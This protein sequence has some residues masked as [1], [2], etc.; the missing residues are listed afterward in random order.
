MDD[1]LQQKYLSIPEE[2]NDRFEQ[3][4]ARFN[5]ILKEF[6]PITL[7]EM[8]DV[9]LMN[10]VDTKFLLNINDLPY[11]LEKAKKQYRVVSIKGEKISP[12][13][14][15]YFDTE[16]SN[17]YISHHNGKRNRYKVRTRTYINP[18]I[19]FL[20]IKHKNN[21]GRVS[22]S[23]IKIPLEQFLH[24]RFNQDEAGFIEK[25]SPYENSHLEPKLQNYFQRVTLVDNAKTERVTI[26]LGVYFLDVKTGT[27][28]MI[29]D[30]VIVEM[31]QDGANRSYFRNYLYES[32][33][34]PAGMSKYCLGMILLDPDIKYNRF[35]RKIRKIN[36]ITEN[37]YATI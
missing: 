30:L 28:E 16:D 22:K 1:L 18:K 21:K 24:M 25:K 14:T 34:A 17:M 7:E 2:I 4:G 23:R 37:N 31:K 8:D 32:R 3:V 33:I 27:I 10:R 36:K 6:A 12:Y 35:K 19:S 26:D 5:R 11:L 15:I 9:K 20:E 29:E 13:T